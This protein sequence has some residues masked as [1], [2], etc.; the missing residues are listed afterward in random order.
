MKVTGAVK[1]CMN[2]FYCKIENERV[3]YLDKRSVFCIIGVLIVGGNIALECKPT[4]V[5]YPKPR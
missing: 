1:C 3:S 2:D 4:T 5:G